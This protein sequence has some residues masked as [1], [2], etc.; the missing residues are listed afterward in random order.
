MA[1]G[2][3]AMA[4]AGLPSQGHHLGSAPC[5]GRAAPGALSAEQNRDLRG[6]PPMRSS[7]P[8]AQDQLP[9][10]GE[11]SSASCLGCAGSSGGAAAFLESLQRE[12]SETQGAG[13]DGCDKA[14][15]TKQAGLRR[16]TLNFS[17]MVNLGHR[18]RGFPTLAVSGACQRVPIGKSTCL[19]FLCKGALA[20]QEGGQGGKKP[21]CPPG[22]GRITGQP[23]HLSTQNKAEIALPRSPYLCE[24]RSHPRERSPV[25]PLQVPTIQGDRSQTSSS[26]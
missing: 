7:P 3:L 1:G 15:A 21:V 17:F 10:G 25:Q 16:F 8:T 9:A 2:G 19:L 26:L 20:V 11:R 6:P 4:D 12:V 14:Q 5:P 18:A 24:C 23:G 22:L 13:E